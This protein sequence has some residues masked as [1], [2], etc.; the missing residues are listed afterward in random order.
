MENLDSLFDATDRLRCFRK[1]FV[2]VAEIGRSQLF[3]DPE[4]VEGDEKIES[5]RSTIRSGTGLP[6][7][8]VVHVSER[9]RG[10]YHLLEG[11]HRYNAAYRELARSI[12]AW[13]AHI[14]CCGGPAA[15]LDGDV[16]GRRMNP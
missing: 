16:V 15:D 7:I 13:V 4:D 14:E 9:R 2:P 8:V 1:E 12:Y 11:R 3:D 5:I 10:P 6:A